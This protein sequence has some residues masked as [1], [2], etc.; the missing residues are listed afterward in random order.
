M[1]R[2]KPSSF[3]HPKTAA[4]INQYYDKWQ[5]TRSDER[6]GVHRLINSAVVAVEDLVD[7]T[8]YVENMFFP[9]RMDI[10]EPWILYK[11]DLPASSIYLTSG[12][13]SSKTSSFYTEA[14]SLD[15]FFSGY[16]TSSSEESVSLALSGESKGIC[17]IKASLEHY[18]NSIY[19]QS[20]NKLIV[21]DASDNLK[22]VGESQLVPQTSGSIEFYTD[23]NNR[24]FP[25][26][27]DKPNTYTLKDSN[28]KSV[29]H[30]FITQETSSGFYD[31]SLDIDHDGIICDKEKSAFMKVYGT[32]MTDYTPDEWDT[33]SWADI[34]GDGII[35][36]KDLRSINAVIPALRSDVV[37]A[38]HVT[39]KKYAG[40][41]IFSY[42]TISDDPVY[43]YRN[44]DNL[45][46]STNNS[47]HI[48]HGSVCAYDDY[49]DIHYVLDLSSNTLKSV[50][51]DGDLYSLLYHGKWNH[52]SKFIDID[53]YNGI[54]YALV[55]DNT[56]CR[57]Y[58]HEMRNESDNCLRSYIPVT[59]K[60]EYG[61]PLKFSL[62]SDNKFVILYENV[63]V[64]YKM[65]KKDYYTVNADG[66]TTFF[67]N[68]F[69]AYDISWNKIEPQRHYVFNSFDSFAY[70]LGITRP[71]GVDNEKLRDIIYDFFLYPQGHGKAETTYGI[72][73][74][75]GYTNKP[76]INPN[77]IYDFP[78][79]ITPRS[80]ISI[81]NKVTSEIKEYPVEIS[82]V[83]IIRG[84]TSIQ[85]HKEFLIANRG[86]IVT[87]SGEFTDAYGNSNPLTVEFNIPDYADYKQI[88]VHSFR[89]IDY[90]DEKGY[91]IS[92][93]VTDKLI[94]VIVNLEETSAITYNNLIPDVTVF[95]RTRI[96]SCPRVPTIFDTIVNSSSGEIEVVI[97]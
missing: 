96:P 70:S 68:K 18:D 92:G 10:D 7:E 22:V 19:V 36:E 23:K 40:K 16:F 45:E 31:S 79:Y 87:L 38:I 9:D 63:L 51:T 13:I 69:D 88:E 3:Y 11:F 65:S 93:E 55:Y 77:T 30:L 58:F 25:L 59:V 73:R 61:K 82:G 54:L 72:M 50:S 84:N 85:F 1:R 42:S 66:V 67:H 27:I 33:V 53:F 71:Y 80:K 60:P 44:K 62:T 20:G 29:D 49:L 97:E 95:G 14:A 21:Y 56:S 75:L 94:D 35:D 57:V 5:L 17:S 24:V 41:C 39:T 64:I 15:S 32:K 8:K 4:I 81:D 34:N 28:G 76:F 12:D 74:D 91:I 86:S 37:S 6:E 46:Y 89:D 47:L 48:N 26:G 43:L 83:G 52:Y 2:Q 90:L 78:G